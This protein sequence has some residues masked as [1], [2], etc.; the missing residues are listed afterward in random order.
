M[1]FPLSCLRLICSW[2][3]V[4]VSGDHVPPQFGDNVQDRQSLWKSMFLR[5]WF[6]FSDAAKGTMPRDPRLEQANYQAEIWGEDEGRSKS[7]WLVKSRQVTQCTHEAIANQYFTGQPDSRLVKKILNEKFLGQAG[8]KEVA[9]K[10]SWHCHSGRCSLDSMWSL[11]TAVKNLKIHV[12]SLAV[13]LLG[14]YLHG[15]NRHCGLN[16]ATRITWLCEP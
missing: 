12:L 5:D 11:V 9:V 16:C 8:C 6:L 14:I 13:P 4:R 2:H 10:K 1:T 7:T 15:I 3:G